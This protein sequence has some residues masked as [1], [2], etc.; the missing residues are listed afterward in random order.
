MAKM[1]QYGRHSRNLGLVN[2]SRV[3]KIALPAIPEMEWSAGHSK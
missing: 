1:R 2:A 3:A